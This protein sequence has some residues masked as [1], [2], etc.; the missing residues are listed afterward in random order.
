MP[1]KVYPLPWQAVVLTSI[2]ERWWSIP[3]P[4]DV[5]TSGIAPL[6]GAST[7]AATDAEGV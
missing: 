2:W 1:P 3:S 7:D 6:A 4:L 5:I